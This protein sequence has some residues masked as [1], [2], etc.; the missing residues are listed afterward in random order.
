MAAGRRATARAF[1]ALG[2]C[3]LAAAAPAPPADLAVPLADGR[4]LNLWCSGAPPAA[5]SG[6]PTILLEAGWGA[7]SRAWSSV[8]GPLAMR[9]RTCAIDRA[10]AGRSSPGPLPRDGRAIARDLGEAL[11]A[12][13]IAPPY[14]LVG[15]S[16]GGLY[17]RQFASDRPREVLGLVLVDPSMP[18][19]RTGAPPPDHP[20]AAR[21]RLCLEAARRGPIPASDPALAGCAVAPAERLAAVWEAR[22]SE[23]ETLFSTTADALAHAPALPARVPVIILTA[24]RGHPGPEAA[25]AWFALHR[26]LAARFPA[27]EA[28]LV[29][30]SGHLMPREAPE[31]IVRAVDDVLARTGA[32]ARVPAGGC[33]ARAGAAA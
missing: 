23:I 22:L 29:A 30:E 20:A 17:V 25:E 16:A 7:D 3:F 21:A 33:R 6:L 8:I 10:G 9:H 31:A 13:G 11:A 14:L 15:H 4:I 18:P 26:G 27:G 28:R 24:G 1:A 12:A 19:P 32:G 5:G 2:A